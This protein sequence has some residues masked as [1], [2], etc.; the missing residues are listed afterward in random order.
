MNLDRLLDPDLPASLVWFV[1]VWLFAV[2]GCIGSFMNV[3]IYRL[4]AGLSLLHPPSRCPAC[5]TPIRATDNVPIFGWLWLRGRC[6]ACGARISPRYPAVELLV[7]M[8]FAGLAWVEPLW[9]LNLPESAGELTTGEVWGLYAYHLFL[10]CSLICAAFI[11]FDAHVLPPRLAVPALIV[12]LA[13]PL[14]WPQ[15][16]LNGM[17]VADSSA[18]NAIADGVVGVVIGAV[19]GWAAGGVA[20]A[21]SR[22]NLAIRRDFAIALSWVGAFLGWQSAAGVAAAALLTVLVTMPVTRRIRLTAWIAVWC[23]V[24]ILSSK[25]WRLMFASVMIACGCVFANCEQASLL[26]AEPTRPT[27]LLTG[28]HGKNVFELRGL[29]DKAASAPAVDFAKRFSVYCVLDAKLGD[30]PP[31]AGRYENADSIVRFTPLF[32]LQPGMKYRVV[33]RPDGAAAEAITQ[34]FELPPESARPPA[35]L[36]TIYPTAAKLPQNQLK[37]YLYFSAPMSRGA[38]YDH[39]ELLD[40][41]GEP[42]DLPFLELAEELWNPAGDRLTLLLDPAR[43]KQDLQ[44]RKVEGPVLVTGRRYTLVVNHEWPDASGRPLA[45]DFRKTFEVAEPDEDCPNPKRW[46]LHPPTAGSRTALNVEFGEPLDRALLDRMLWVVDGRGRRIPGEAE[47]GKAE[48]TWSFRP[49]APWQPGDYQLTADALI[50]DL[51]GNS[52]ARKFEL[53]GQSTSDDEAKLATVG[54]RIA[55]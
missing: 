24:S 29:P 39:L 11:E 21:V 28:V 27:I 53:V 37:F 34:I 18:W 16:R 52:I 41:H 36:L 47:V 4:P 10:L 6:R 2:G 38:A 51:A 5:E 12:G 40:A 44:P 26:A 20:K 46:R 22:D 17:A 43:V 32:P 15:L 54:F 35:K 49:D 13:A 9:R 48:S 50:E 30:Q 23:L 19:S 33:Y 14:V 42:V 31:L 55:E 8:L 7:A 1:L 45:A 3:V 25:A